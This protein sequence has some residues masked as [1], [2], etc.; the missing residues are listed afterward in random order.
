MKT[1]RNLTQCGLCSSSDSNHITPE[2]KS[3]KLPFETAC[4]VVNNRNASDV[5][6]LISSAIIYASE[7]HFSLNLII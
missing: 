1:T 3:K 6:V 4:S 2:Y 5:Q 7:Y